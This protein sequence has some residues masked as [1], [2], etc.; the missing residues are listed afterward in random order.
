LQTRNRL[1]IEDLLNPEVEAVAFT[2]TDKELCDAVKKSVESRDK[3]E[4]NGGDDDLE[5]DAIIE[6]PPSHRDALMA[7]SVLASFTHNIN[8]PLARK[9]ED[10]LVSF[11]RQVHLEE[12]QSMH[13][14]RITDYFSYV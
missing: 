11:R 2:G 13:A 12:M 1:R 5:D 7:A 14:T 6:P 9:L 4:A 3:A 8:S 10:V